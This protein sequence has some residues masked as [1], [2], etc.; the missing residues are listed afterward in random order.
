MPKS[1]TLEKKGRKG[2]E[3]KGEAKGRKPTHLIP[4]LVKMPFRV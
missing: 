2:N 4:W 1:A 3:K